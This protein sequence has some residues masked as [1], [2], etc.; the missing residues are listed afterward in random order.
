MAKIIYNQKSPNPQKPMIKN[1]TLL[2]LMFFLFNRI[3]GQNQDFDFEKKNYLELTGE[4]GIQINF[5]EVN[6]KYQLQEDTIFYANSGFL[7][8][9]ERDTATIAG[10][11]YYRASL[12][13]SRLRT[14]D[15]ITCNFS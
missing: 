2:I 11:L 14:V 15:K 7:I 6:V 10:K 3:S 8:D 9:P 4:N 12:K 13:T 5:Y 1:V